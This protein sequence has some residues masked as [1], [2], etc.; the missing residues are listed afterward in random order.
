MGAVSSGAY[1]VQARGTPSLWPSQGVE[2]SQ[3]MI[4]FQDGWNQHAEHADFGVELFH[5][6]SRY[7][8]WRG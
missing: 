5:A 8:E 1:P 6:S 7:D 3:S 4:E 2:W